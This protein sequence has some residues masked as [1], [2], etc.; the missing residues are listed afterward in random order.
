MS[1]ERTHPS[2][3]TRYGLRD[4]AGLSCVLTYTADPDEPATWKIR[5]PGPAAPKTST[6]PSG[7]PTPTPRD[8]RPG[9]APSSAAA[10]PPNSPAPSMPHRRCQVSVPK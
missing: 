7:S 10:M 4:E 1:V 3:Q 6:A 2:H 8:S 9:S 5:L